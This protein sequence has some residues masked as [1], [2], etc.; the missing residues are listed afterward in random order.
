MIQV[1]TLREKAGPRQKASLSSLTLTEWRSSSAPSSLNLSPGPQPSPLS[2]SLSGNGHPLSPHLS[3][4]DKES[5]AWCVF[6]A[7]V[8]VSGCEGGGWPCPHCSV[9]LGWTWEMVSFLLT[10]ESD[11]LAQGPAKASG[12][13]L[14]WPENRGEPSNKCSEAVSRENSGSFQP[15]LCIGPEWKNG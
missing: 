10:T 15:D 14:V 1:S 7:A 6:P 4:C 3:A 5:V 11:G 8:K 12:E 13:R 2:G 9:T